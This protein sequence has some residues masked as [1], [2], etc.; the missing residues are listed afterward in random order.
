YRIAVTPHEEKFE[1]AASADTLNIPLGGLAMVTVNTVRGSFGGPIS[2]TLLDAPEGITATPAVIGPG[3][4]TTV[5]TIQ[6]AANVP[7]G[8]VYPLRIAGTSQAGAVNYQAVATV[9]AAQ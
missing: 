1:L 6:A 3:M 4:T 9:T 5:M 2:L 8:K 7:P